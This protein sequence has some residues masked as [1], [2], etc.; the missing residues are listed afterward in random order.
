M[1]IIRPLLAAIVLVTATTT[2]VWA[3]SAP[4]QEASAPA[5]ADCVKPMH[6]HGAQKGTPMAHKHCAESVAPA[7][8]AA[9]AKAKSKPIHDHGKMHKNQ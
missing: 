2:A 7:A 4:A 5:A 6:D 1:S 3:Q 9:G 8:S